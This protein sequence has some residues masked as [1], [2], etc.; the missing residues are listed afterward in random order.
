MVVQE[1]S[2]NFARTFDWLSLLSLQRKVA[3]KQEL[4]YFFGTVSTPKAKG[5]LESV[6]GPGK[7]E[8]ETELGVKA[9]M[10]DID[11]KKLEIE[12]GGGQD[13]PTNYDPKNLNKATQREVLEDIVKNFPTDA[14]EVVFRAK[15]ALEEMPT[16][17][18]NLQGVEKIF[19]FQIAKWTPRGVLRK[20]L[21]IKNLQSPLQL[22]K[23]ELLMRKIVT[24]M[25][26]PVF[27]RLKNTNVTDHLLFHD[28]QKYG[29]TTNADLAKEVQI[30]LCKNKWWQD[31]GEP[32]GKETRVP[33]GIMKP[34]LFQL[35]GTGRSYAVLW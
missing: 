18:D 26:D 31:V 24:R 15:G 28:G 21:G 30:E 6:A 16:S 27:R 19:H 11:R 8:F 34:L 20:L 22:M 32:I 33:G 3:G 29:V 5:I 9:R 1:F 7:T 2:L 13:D 4:Y 12:F 23:P 10:K 14:P 35:R 25:N 17:M